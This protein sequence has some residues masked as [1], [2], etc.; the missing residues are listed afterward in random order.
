MIQ[1]AKLWIEI[2]ETKTSF[3]DIVDIILILDIE[4][5]TL[6]VRRTLTTNQMHI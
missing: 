6:L 3:S 4:E 1:S 2:E 5:E